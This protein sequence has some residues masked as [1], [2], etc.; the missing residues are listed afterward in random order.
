MVMLFTACKKEAANT[1]NTSNSNNNTPTR[2]V[3][4]TLVGPVQEKKIY[5][6]LNGYSSSDD[7]EASG[8]Y[9]Q[10]N[11]FYVVFDNRFKIGSFLNSL[12]S[13]SASNTLLGSGSGS[14][15]FEGITYDNYGTPNWYIVEESAS[16]NGAYYPRVY[17]YNASWAYQQNA[18]T[19]YSFNSTNNNKAFEG[20]AYLRRNGHDYVLGIV[21][22]TGKIA[23]MIQNGNNWDYV[24]EFSIPEV[25]T[26]YSDIALYGNKLAVC[27][28]ED[29]KI[30]VGTLSSTSWSTTGSG[31]VY[32][33][34]TGSSTGV[35]GAGTYT[36]YANV[37]GISFINDTTLVT[38][39]DK[40]NNLQPAYQSYK[41][42]SIQTFILR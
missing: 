29:A 21:E 37:E 15:N 38:C 19:N 7:F 11:Y 20:I 25:F 34:P 24:T 4:K 18:W 40:A 8:V 33:F 39:S 9:A 1:V 5:K 42:Q 14:S 30:W 22:S 6:L 28:Q 2:V 32:L 36:L 35:V 31:T 10:G 27:S 3:T 23:V 26:D 41:D 13:N 12:P 16:H 17:E